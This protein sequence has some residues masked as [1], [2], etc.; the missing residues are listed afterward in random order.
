MKKPYIKG[1]PNDKVIEDVKKAVN[2]IYPPKENKK[3]I[4]I[5][6]VYSHLYKNEDYPHIN[7]ATSGRH[8]KTVMTYI[9]RDTFKWELFAKAEGRGVYVRPPK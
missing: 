8:I 7:K 9:F 4:V 6:T 1:V 5:R 3:F 2:D